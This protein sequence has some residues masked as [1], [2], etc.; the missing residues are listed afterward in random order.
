MASPAPMVFA[1]LGQ[2]YVKTIE[3]RLNAEN[4]PKISLVSRNLA[5]RESHEVG[6]EGHRA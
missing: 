4:Q 2:F 3:K 1:G 5:A 6:H